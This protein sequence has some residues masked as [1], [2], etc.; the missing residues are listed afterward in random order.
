MGEELFYGSET[1]SDF[2]KV[3]QQ[4][5][6]RDKTRLGWSPGPHFR[7]GPATP[8]WVAE[9]LLSSGTVLG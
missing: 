3:T 4:E 7:L 5:K 8:G 2:S 1:L 6:D 9:S